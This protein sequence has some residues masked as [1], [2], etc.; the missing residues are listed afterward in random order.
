VSYRHAFLRHAAIDPLIAPLDALRNRVTD[1]RISAPTSLPMDDRDAWLD[2]LLVNLVEPRLG[3]ESPTILY[4]YPA[5]Q[6]ALAR[7]RNEDP[8]VAERFELYV[9]GVELANGYHELTDADALVERMRRGNAARIADGKEALP[10]QNRLLAA[11]RGG[12]PDCAGVA[13][14]FDRV[15]M[16]AAGARTLAEVV[17]FPFNRA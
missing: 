17:A 9:R 10:M 11:M 5:S 12:L 8:P 13:L 4:D 14:G 6:A 2:L 16:L 3:A 1:A 7:V 15:V